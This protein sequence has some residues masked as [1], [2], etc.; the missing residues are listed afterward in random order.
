MSVYGATEVMTKAMLAMELEKHKGESHDYALYHPRGARSI[1]S[2]RF[3][4]KAGEGSSENTTLEELLGWQYI[5]AVVSRPGRYEF[6]EKALELCLP[7]IHKCPACNTPIM[8]GNVSKMCDACVCSERAH[9]A[10]TEA[11]R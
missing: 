9:R 8:G 7:N 3:L 11:K 4:Q 2:G 10:T 1:F 6:T 5:V